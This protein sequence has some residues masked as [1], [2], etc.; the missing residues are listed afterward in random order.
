MATSNN[1]I[2]FRR[3]DLDNVRTFLTGL[4]VVHHSAIAYGGPGS[5][6]YR[7]T[8]FCD[9]ASEPLMIFNVFNQSFFMGAFFWISGRMSAEALARPAAS[10]AAFARSKI[11][12]LGVPT[13]VYSAV[14]FPLCRLL[15]LP[16][17][18]GESVKTSLRKSWQAFSGARGPVWYTA[19]LLAFD[20]VAA[21]A[22]E[23]LG[24]VDLVRKMPPSAFTAVSRWGWLAAALVSLLVRLQYPVTGVAQVPLISGMPGYIVQY[25]YAYVLGWLAY[26]HGAA[27]M[28]SPFEP[29]E[30][31]GRG[32]SLIQATAVSLATEVLVLAPALL[33]LNRDSGTA[34]LR[35]YLGG[36][37][38][39]AVLYAIW[40]EFSFVIITPAL[41]S[42]FQRRYYTRVTSKLW[43]PRY[44]YAAFF[45]HT[46]VSI[47]VGLLV[48][49][50]L[51]P[52]AASPW[53]Q[54]VLWKVAGPTGMTLLV[55]ALNVVTSFTIG[56]LLVC[57]IPGVSKFL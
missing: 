41:M 57:Y 47:G 23:A 21:A 19:T 15:T 40:N 33:E 14:V 36:W 6:G 10:T 11:V 53:M 44:S 29:A 4:V 5:W 7:S 22:V 28:T 52:Y 50:A 56:R 2:S 26:H 49:A 46:P 32:M 27:R 9:R 37:N 55:G 51:P 12:R 45:V 39:K 54:S 24:S 38:Y 18:D 17:W 3:H 25:V 16:R 1:I 20:L 35:D 30:G 42:L 31:Q 8:L 43:S 48:D 13:L 34:A